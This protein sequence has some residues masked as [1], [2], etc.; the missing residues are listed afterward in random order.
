M[1]G[2][3]TQR[4][5]VFRTGESVCALPLACVVETL[6]PLPLRSVAGAPPFVAGVSIIRGAPVPIISA[7]LLLDG[8]ANVLR[9]LLIVRAGDRRVGLAVD[10]IEG[11]RFLDGEQ[12]LGL[13]P[14]LHRESASVESLAVADGELLVVLAA[15]R[16]L[17]PHAE[18][19][20]DMKG[21][22]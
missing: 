14:L 19:L 17:P 8:I 16:L 4:F 5:V 11:I 22:A 15:G 3:S 20:F 10:E 6:R 21:A 1:A 9:R 12:V 18:D 7:A 2:N 13:P